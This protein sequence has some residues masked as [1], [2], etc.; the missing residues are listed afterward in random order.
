MTL[1]R[2]DETIS[3]APQ[4]APEE[5]PA[6]AAAG[7]KAIVNNRPEEE[8]YDQPAGDAVR[9]AAEAAGLSYVAIPVTHAGFAAWQVEAMAE[10]LAAADGPVLAFCRS[11]T[12]SCNLWALA[13]A[14]RGGDPE[15]LT[16]KA[17]GA[18]YDISGI[19]P[20]LDGLSGQA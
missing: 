2:I 3:V 4:I 20:L 18:G 19:R 15:E 13:Q 11:G 6:L 10:A 14:S 9:A 17:A 16:A 5:V 12:R 7:F 8:E 1:R